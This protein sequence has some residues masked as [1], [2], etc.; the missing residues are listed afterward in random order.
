[1]AAGDNS[2]RPPC[3]NFS[4]LGPLG[5]SQPSNSAFSMPTSNSGAAGPVGGA[6]GTA[7]RSNP[8]SG[9]GGAESNGEIGRA[10]C[11]GRV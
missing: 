5:N 1:M 10:S 3:L 6:Q 2:G 11:R 9:P 8:Q 4:G 7:R